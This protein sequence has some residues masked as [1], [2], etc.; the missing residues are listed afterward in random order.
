MIPGAMNEKDEAKGAFED[1]SALLDRFQDR[2]KAEGLLAEIR[3][4]APSRKLTIMNVCGTHEH[5]I[6]QWGLRSL[7]P[8]D[9]E[10]IAGPGCPVC[11]CPTHEIKEALALARKGVILATFGDMLKVRTKEGSLLDARS[12]GAR[13]TLVYSA[14]DALKLA[15][16]RPDD[17]VVFFSVG[18]E[19]TSAPTAAL[20]VAGEIPGNFSVLTSQRLTPPAVEFLCRA[21]DGPID[22]FIAP[23]HVSCI[24]G[25]R[26][27]KA[28][29]DEFGKPTVVAGFEPLDLLLAFRTILQQI[30]ED[31]PELANDYRR[32][33][34]FEGNL[35]AQELMNRAFEVQSSFWR[36]IGAIEGSG[37]LLSDDF[38]RFDARERFGVRLEPQP[39]ED[40]PEGCSC[41]EVLLGRV[42]PTDCPLF[43]TGC[44]PMN[45]FGPC[46]VSQEGTC[47]IWYKY[48]RGKQKGG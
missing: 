15:A 42:Y 21:G 2:E 47:L 26:G 33:V 16:D 25:A 8:E 18:F 10:L 32:S 35:R 5:A 45:P 22:A 41:G 30:T 28:I 38:R 37:L 31:R 43:G 13:V 24:T 23:G 14:L 19:T 6:A 20:L 27:W 12:E 11:V 17:D 36:G 4:L 3:R 7:I 40:I 44:T 46:M 1:A 48:K 34:T 9:I 39:E 29:P